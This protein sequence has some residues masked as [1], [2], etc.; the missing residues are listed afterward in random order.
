MLRQ[1][2]LFA[3]ASSIIGNL[4]AC[5]VAQ[6]PN[7]LVVLVD[8]LRW[9]D[10][11]CA[12]HPFS[13]TPNMDRIADEGA[14]FLNAFATTPLCS[15]SR[16]SLL[17]G[18]HAHSHGII[19]NTDR[20][21]QSH[22]LKTFPQGL[23]QIGYETAYIGKWHMGNDDLPRPGFDQ[24]VCL[25]GQGTT[26]DPEVNVNGRVSKEAGYVT[27]I[28]DGHAAEFIKRSR[29]KPFL[30]YFAHKAMHPETI[31]RA[32]GSLSD[33][34]ASTFIPADRHQSLFAGEKIPRRAN[35][36]VSPH[37]KPALQ[38][39]IDGV[40][41]LSPQTGSSDE[42]I[43]GRL[44]ML[45]AVDES[46]GHMIEL[47]E[48]SGELDRTLIVVTSDHGYFYGEHGL[49]VERRLAYEESIRIPMLMRLP[50]RIQPHTTPI[51]LVLT[52]DL[53]PTLLEFGGA[54]VPESLHGHSL[55]PIFENRVV[56]WRNE[57]LIEYF[58]DKVFPRMTQM[59]YQAVRT[60]RHKYI[61]YS[62]LPEMDELYDLDTDPFEMNN[63]FNDPN[64]TTTRQQ[65]QMILSRIAKQ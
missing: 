20:S 46:L 56:N 13:M 58:S 57:F 38:R 14:R 39:T 5:S 19:D 1:I 49:S 55:L 37:D 48:K 59:G 65:M 12:G 25:K 15:P 2:A 26:W 24:W 40:P 45:A 44:R 43:L 47:L 16:A 27:D 35:A 30:L 62:E 61:R 54:R 22:R 53:A 34:S 21:Q 51:E 3:F 28:L 32:D 9:D 52:I 4:A 42:S 7:L 60:Q 50:G 17:T 6:Q 10:L 8:D 31:Q 41:P 18:L 23:Q 64:S 36:L 33:P 29:S 11:G 63:L